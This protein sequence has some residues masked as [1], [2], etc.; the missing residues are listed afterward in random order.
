[1]PQGWDLGI[2]DKGWGQLKKKIDGEEILNIQS[3]EKLQASVHNNYAGK[4]IKQL[5][6][7]VQGS[8]EWISIAY[9][10]HK[11]GQTL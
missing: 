5:C 4:K 1:M 11:L 7:L 3:V 2:C 10:R 6:K 9:K 8:M